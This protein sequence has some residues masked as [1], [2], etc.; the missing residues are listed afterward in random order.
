MWGVMAGYPTR[1]MKNTE[2]HMA[3]C[4]WWDPEYERCSILG[5]E[6][7]ISAIND[8]IVELTNRTGEI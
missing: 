2:C 1:Y 5:I 6:E 7:A 3:E 4:A 8:N